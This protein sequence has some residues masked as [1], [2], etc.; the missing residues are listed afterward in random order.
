MNH[1]LRA[2]FCLLLIIS[3]AIKDP[4]LPSHFSFII[5]IILPVFMAF[6]F[7]Y[8]K[9]FVADELSGMKEIYNQIINFHRKLLNNNT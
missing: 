8:S 2:L 6:E 4:S 1:Y 9:F 7:C 5:F 3:V